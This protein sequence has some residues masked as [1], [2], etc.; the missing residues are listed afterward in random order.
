[1]RSLVRVTALG[2]GLLLV[3]GAAQAQPIPPGHMPPPGECR[4]WLPDRPPGHQ[5]PPTSCRVAERQ[6]DRFGGFVVYGGRRDRYDDRYD[7]DHRDRYRGRHRDRYEDDYGERRDDYR[8]RYRDRYR[9][10]VFLDWALRNFD[11]DRDGRLDRYERRR[12]VAAWRRR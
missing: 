4:V 1:M 3:A 7:D 10:S 8:D 9:E 2:A 11:Y 12:A 6:A 5:P